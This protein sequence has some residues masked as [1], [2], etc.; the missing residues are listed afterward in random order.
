M[1]EAASVKGEGRR[2]CRSPPHCQ[3][4]GEKWRGRPWSAA[5]RG[6]WRASAHRDRRHWTPGRRTSRA[7]VRR[8]RRDGAA[9]LVR[10]RLRGL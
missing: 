9:Q 1:T 6:G 8:L 4:N 7:R 2:R 10:A 3:R 5:P